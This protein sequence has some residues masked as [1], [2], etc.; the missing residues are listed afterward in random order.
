VH[1]GSKNQ[2]GF[3]RMFN[4]LSTRVGIP[5]EKLPG[6]DA[7]L[8]GITE[9]CE[10]VFARLSKRPCCGFLEE[11]AVGVLRSLGIVRTRF[12]EVSP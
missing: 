5:C 4:H 10:E 1:I 9:L 2:R 12:G 7:D 11:C 3:L 8:R 6:D